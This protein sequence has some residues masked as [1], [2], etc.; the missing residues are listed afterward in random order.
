MITCIESAW[1]EA[2]ISP[3]PN[4]TILDNQSGANKTY[5]ARDYVSMKP[6]FKYTA[7]GSSKFNAKIDAGLLFPSSA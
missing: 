1:I 5:V 6:G 2:Q 3:Q 4:Y 7:T